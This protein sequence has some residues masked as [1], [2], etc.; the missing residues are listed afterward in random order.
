MSW[1]AQIEALKAAGCERVYS[2]RASPGADSRSLPRARAREGIP[3]VLNRIEL[4][5][6]GWQRDDGDVGRYDEA[7]VSSRTVSFRVE[8]GIKLFPQA[9]GIARR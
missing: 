7:M 2:E 4:G 1:P 9:V 5:T 8:P 3:H 6:F